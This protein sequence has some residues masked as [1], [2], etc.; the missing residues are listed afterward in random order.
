M[1]AGT[2]LAWGRAG[3]ARFWFLPGG[4]VSGGARAPCSWAARLLGGCRPLP[5]GGVF[6]DPFPFFSGTSFRLY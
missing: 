5:R 2:K 1:G 3:M 4:R 6:K